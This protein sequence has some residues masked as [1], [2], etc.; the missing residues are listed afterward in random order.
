MSSGGG[1]ACGGAGV[2]RWVCVAVGVCGGVGV[3]RWGRV[4][5][6]VRS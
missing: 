6:R 5:V 1:G 2:W 3:W 4:A